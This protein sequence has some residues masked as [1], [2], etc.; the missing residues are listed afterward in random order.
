MI[1]QCADAQY[2]YLLSILI[3]FLGHKANIEL[4]KCYGS[5]YP[6]Y[7]SSRPVFVFVFSAQVSSDVWSSTGEG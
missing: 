6:Y 4:I 2:R 1:F 7:L 5:L 3:F